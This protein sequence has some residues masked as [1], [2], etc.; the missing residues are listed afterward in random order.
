[1]I[2]ASDDE[3]N[4]FLALEDPDNQCLKNETVGQLSNM[5]LS[6]DYPRF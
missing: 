3:I 6:L 4:D 2:T 5:T 1:M